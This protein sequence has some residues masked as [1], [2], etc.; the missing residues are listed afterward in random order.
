[1]QGSALG[2]RLAPYDEKNNNVLRQPLALNRFCNT[3]THN[4]PPIIFLDK[5]YQKPTTD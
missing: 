5:K 1:M 4:Q 3:R 2:D